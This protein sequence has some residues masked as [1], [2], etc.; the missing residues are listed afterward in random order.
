ITTLKY[1]ILKEGRIENH[2]AS[3]SPASFKFLDVDHDGIEEIVTHHL[4]FEWFE[5]EENCSIMSFYPEYFETL[6]YFIPKILTFKNDRFVDNTFEFKEY[7]QKHYLALLEKRLRIDEYEKNYIAGFIQ[8]FF[9]S[10]QLK[11]R[12][13]ALTFIKK[14]NKAFQY[15]HCQDD[16]RIQTTVFDFI[17]KHQQ[18][19]IKWWAR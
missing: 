16:I 7:L 14:N 10:A 19:I 11:Q 9:I 17:K 18:D 8:Y 15:Y 5:V 12:K 6:E 4:R 13:A 2:V 1:V 3:D